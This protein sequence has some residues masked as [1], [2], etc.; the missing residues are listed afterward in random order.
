MLFVTSGVFAA[1]QMRVLL[2]WDSRSVHLLLV[3]DVSG[4]PMGSNFK[5]QAAESSYTAWPLKMGPI[6]CPKYR[7]LTTNVHYI[8]CQTSADLSDL[9]RLICV[10]E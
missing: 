10:Q 8:T 4:Q 2:F 3:T 5:G 1:E 6:E 7:Q 9:M